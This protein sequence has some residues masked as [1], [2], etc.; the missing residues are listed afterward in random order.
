M[1]T[2]PGEISSGA[3]SG[4]PE[5]GVAVALGVGLTVGVDVIVGVGVLVTSIVGVGV[6]LDPDPLGMNR[7]LLD[8]LLVP[9][10][11]EAFTLQ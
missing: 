6:A 9:A 7:Q 5:T 8:Q 4:D 1:P 2:L 3:E 10:G 11:F